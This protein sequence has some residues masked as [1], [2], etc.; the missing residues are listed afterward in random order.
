[1]QTQQ[2][3]F[4]QK[5]ALGAATTTHAIA[6]LCDYIEGLRGQHDR[7]IFEQRAEK[8]DLQRGWIATITQPQ[9]EKATANAEMASLRHRGQGTLSGPT[10]L[11]SS[12]TFARNKIIC[13]SRMQHSLLGWTTL[14]RKREDETTAA[15]H[16]LYLLDWDDTHDDKVH[17]PPTDI[18]HE[19]DGNE[20]ER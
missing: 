9:N 4:E 16:S 19:G 13:A 8:E 15:N 1:M 20:A 14:W 11:R 12:S 2:P 5:Q 7:T 6:Q 18:W 10:Q 17:N 3:Y